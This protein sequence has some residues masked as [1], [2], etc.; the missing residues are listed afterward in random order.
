VLENLARAIRPGGLLVV[1]DS[2]GAPPVALQDR[3]R[4]DRFG[5]AFLTAAAGNGWDLTWAPCLP[6]RLGEL[7]L[8]DI[9]ARAFREYV[10]GSEDGFP[11][12]TALSVAQLYERLLATGWVEPADLDALIAAL[13]DPACAFLTFECWV[14]SGRRPA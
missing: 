11:A 5:M 12:F 13:R 10:A 6:Q 3:E 7:G 1:F 8:V 9:R 14:A 2:G 4:F